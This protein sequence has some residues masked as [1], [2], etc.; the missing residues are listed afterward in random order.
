MTVETAIIKALSLDP[1][2]RKIAA[3]STEAS[4]YARE[5]RA[6][7]RPQIRLEGSAG[8]VNRDRSVDRIAIGGDDLFARDIGIFFEQLIWD[9]GYHWYRWKDSEE[10][11]KG[12]QLLD[13]AQREVTALYTSEVFLDVIRDREQIKLAQANLKVHGEIRDLASKRAQAAG[14]GADVA[15]SR[16][17]YNLALSLLRERQVALRQTEARFVRYVGQ[18]P[19]RRL[20]MPARPLVI[21]SKGGIDPTENFHYQAALRQRTAAELAKKSIRKSYYPQFYFRG[22]GRVGE[23]VQ[24]IKG[25]DNEASAMIIVQ[26]DLFDSGRRKGQAEQALADIDRQQAIID[27]TLVLLDQD[28]E[29]RWQDYS[30]LVERMKIMRD[31]SK[32][33]HKTVTLYEEQF[34]LG[35]RPLLSV[36]DIKNEEI[37]SNIRLTDQER[38]FAYSAYRLLAFGGRMVT[39]TVGESH[40]TQIKKEAPKKRSPVQKASSVRGSS[41]K[42]VASSHTVAKVKSRRSGPFWF[43]KKNR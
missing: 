13:N 10:R 27:E 33:L 19:P 22:G 1:T 14:N 41:G 16:A 11:L 38:D 36:L 4:G 39:D 28:I 8:W 24:G 17:R 15:L 31:Y 18:G 7:L 30:T 34:E 5:V 3:D 6:D 12:K 25:E 42:S 9:G 21:R 29:A 40:L 43:L 2:I 23:D 20:I 37:A 26:W 35:T 32:E